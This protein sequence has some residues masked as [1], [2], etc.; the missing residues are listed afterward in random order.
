MLH[1]NSEW[2]DSQQP[3]IFMRLCK[4]HLLLHSSVSGWLEWF[5][6]LWLI[7]YLLIKKLTNPAVESL[8]LNCL[9][10]AHLFFSY[11]R[12]PWRYLYSGAEE[13]WSSAPSCPL[14]GYHFVLLH[15]SSKINQLVKEVSAVFY[16]LSTCF[17]R[18]PSC[19]MFTLCPLWKKY[20]RYE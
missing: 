6:G 16:R 18:W 14:C 8:F 15:Q 7:N 17:M 3:F 11:Q 5:V 10:S 13:A 1:S 4:G 9:S 20:Q 12:V 19:V 2:C